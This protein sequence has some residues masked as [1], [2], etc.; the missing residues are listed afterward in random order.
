MRPEIMVVT[1]RDRMRR[2][3]ELRLGQ[4]A[5]VAGGRCWD[6]SDLFTLSQL[7]PLAIVDV[8][9]LFPRPDCWGLPLSSA[10]AMPVLVGGFRGDSDALLAALNEGIPV[11]VLEDLAGATLAKMVGVQEGIPGLYPRMGRLCA[12]RV[13]GYLQGLSEGPA[14]TRREAEVLQLVAE[15]YSNRR[16]ARTLGIELRTVKNHLTHIYG[17]LGVTNRCQAAARASTLPI[18]DA[19]RTPGR[20]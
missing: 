18:P 5:G 7:P 15:G 16:I 2:E 9:E 11:Q 8:L 13:W 10:P 4:A 17:K 20:S 3:L 14:L 12:E 6:L 1:H 19:R